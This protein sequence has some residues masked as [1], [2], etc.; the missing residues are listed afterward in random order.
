MTRVGRT[1]A[2]GRALLML[3]ARSAGRITVRFEGKRKWGRGTNK[4]VKYRLG[5][6]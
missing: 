6:S 1:P 3:I 4:R 2:P 5:G